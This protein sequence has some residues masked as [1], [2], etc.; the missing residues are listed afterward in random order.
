MTL[1][2]DDLALTRAKKAAGVTRETWIN[3]KSDSIHPIGVC[4]PSSTDSE[5]HLI[6]VNPDLDKINANYVIC[7]ELKHAAQEE[8]DQRFSSGAYAIELEAAGIDAGEFN[9]NRP[10][11][12]P[13]HLHKAY[14]EMPSEIEADKF[15][16]ENCDLYEVFIG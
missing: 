1:R 13:E 3:L 6:Y 9:A 8:A 16:R 15:A 4:Y 5:P 7:H 14:T 11:A 2:I 10:M 12:L